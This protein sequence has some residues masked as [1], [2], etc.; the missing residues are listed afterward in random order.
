MTMRLR[1]HRPAYTLLEVLL[2]TAIGALL[3]VGLYS[4]LEITMRNAQAGR[5][6]VE[7]ATLARSL[8]LRLANDVSSNLQAAVPSKSGGSSGQGGGSGQGGAAGSTSSQSS[9]SATSSTSGGS[10]SGL[11]GTVAFNM[12]V[13]GDSTHLFLF[14]SRVPRELDPSWQGDAVPTVSDL[15]RITYWLSS[16]GLARQ[17]IKLATSDDAQNLSTDL[18]D[19]PALV[20][21]EEVKS[22][23]FQYFDGTNW[24]DSW[25]GTQTP[26]SGGNNPQGPPQ[27]IA[28][29]IG[30]AIPGSSDDSAEP[31]LKTYRHIIAIPTANGATQ[32]Q[33]GSTSGSSTSP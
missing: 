29:T 18:P 30:L 23:T 24:Q 9:S 3:L 28:I 13:Q 15:R 31:K 11:G 2:A 27:L 6:K 25:D 32:S 20:V 21:A 19:D 10:V 33:N 5:D 17:E 12:G 16:L 4:A 26:A 7:Q 14:S 22:L 8:L 1:P